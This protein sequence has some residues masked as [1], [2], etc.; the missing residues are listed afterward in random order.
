[1]PECRL[2]T[3]QGKKQLRVGGTVLVSTRTSFSSSSQT[4]NFTSYLSNVAQANNSAK[5]K[6][7]NV[8]CKCDSEHY[9]SAQSNKNV[10]LISLR[11]C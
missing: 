7:M 9:L 10:L 5:S 8:P 3:I 6:M 11:H 2:Y 1:M 4:T